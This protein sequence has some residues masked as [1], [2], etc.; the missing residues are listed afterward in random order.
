MYKMMHA[1]TEKQ[2]PEDGGQTISHSDTKFMEQ[3]DDG[4]YRVVPVS[5]VPPSVRAQAAAAII[6]SAIKQAMSILAGIDF[7]EGVH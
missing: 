3:G 2:K 1:I 7:N 5:Q 6:Q 4:E